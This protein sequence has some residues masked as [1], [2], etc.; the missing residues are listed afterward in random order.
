[1]YPYTLAIALFLTVAVPR[2]GLGGWLLS[3]GAQVGVF[4]FQPEDEEPTP[5]YYAVG[6]RL[7]LGYSLAQRFDGALIATYSPGSKG[8]AV[9]GEEQASLVFS[10]FVLALRLEEA[11][12]LGIKGGE[13]RYHLV[14]A[15]GAPGEVEGAWIG[16]SGSVALGAIF[17]V[18]RDASW[19][20]CLE[21]QHA[22]LSQ[23]KGGVVTGGGVKRRLNQVALSL[24]YSYNSFVNS[25][26]AGTLFDGFF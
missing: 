4:S 17:E 13:A 19:E 1:M 22:V 20:L 10:G 16:P 26:I 24:T 14:R 2:D 12:Y 23:V 21:M 5:N 7:S 25:G 8:A 15:S 9:L 6:P 11:L 18:E 3:P